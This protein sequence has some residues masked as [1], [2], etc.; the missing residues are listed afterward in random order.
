MSRER[1]AEKTTRTIPAIGDCIV[2][3]P[4]PHLSVHVVENGFQHAYS[5]AA[6]QVPYCINH[7]GIS[8]TKS[9]PGSLFQDTHVMW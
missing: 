3:N 5:T 1:F 4:K 8:E 6:V 2:I 9:N 7:L